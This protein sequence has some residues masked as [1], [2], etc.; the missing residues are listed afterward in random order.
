MDDAR[1]LRWGGAAGVA[2]AAVAVA[3]NALHPR[4]PSDRLN[5][6][7]ELLRLVSR[8]GDWRIVHLVSVLATLVGV[9]AIVAIL[10]SMSLG[11][12]R[13]WPAIALASLVVTTP[14]LLLSVA[15]DG[16]AIKAV[17]DQWARATGAPAASLLAA[18]TA[19]RSLDEAVLDAVMITQFGLTTVLLGVASWTSPLYGRALGAVALAAGAT[20]VV[21]GCVQALAGRLT[22]FSYLVLLTLSLALFTLW[23][24]LASIRLWR[25]GRSGLTSVG[26]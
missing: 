25:L 13:R 16:F 8:S 26:A 11:G 19:L 10:W 24:T 12:S 22:P 6:V 20:G 3:F 1:L 14:V 4:A 5:D 18:A 2:S 7:E 21:C 23:L 15:V 9:G 17:A